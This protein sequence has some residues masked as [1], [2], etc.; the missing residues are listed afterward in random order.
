MSENMKIQAPS[1]TKREM[2]TT[3]NRT[4]IGFPEQH[5][6]RFHITI[7]SNHNC[8]NLSN[9]Y[10]IGN[11]PHKEFY[12]YRETSCPNDEKSRKESNKLLPKILQMQKKAE[13]DNQEDLII[14]D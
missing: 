1:I 7:I 6:K 2:S 8:K 13:K 4:S 12:I 9:V 3:F 10:S 5:N 11:K 14:F